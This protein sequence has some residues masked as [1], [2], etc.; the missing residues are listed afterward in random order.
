[1]AEF[2][3]ATGVLALC[4]AGFSVKD[5]GGS[6]EARRVYDSGSR[7][8]D[9]TIVIASGEVAVKVDGTAYLPSCVFGAVAAIAE[10]LA[11]EENENG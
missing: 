4:R 8:E 3:G 7:L 5:N 2:N 10:G 1:M 6:V 9:M 11:K